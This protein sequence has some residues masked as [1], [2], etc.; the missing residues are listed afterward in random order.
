M[1]SKPIRFTKHALSY[2]KRRGFT[3]DEVVKCIRDSAWEPADLGRQEC[4]K[5]FPYGKEWNRKIYDFKQI[6]PIFVEEEMEIVVITV[7][8]Y[9]Y[10]KGME[11]ENKL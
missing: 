11:H 9:Y 2:I 6:R 8:T 7:Y 10:Q 3:E 1:G 4:R 5:D